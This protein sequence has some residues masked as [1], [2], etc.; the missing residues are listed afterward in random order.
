[1]E[2]PCYWQPEEEGPKL[3]ADYFPSLVQL[4]GGTYSTCCPICEYVQRIAQR[5][6]DISD[7]P[8]YPYEV[9]IINNSKPEAWSLPEG[10]VGIHR[11]LLAELCS[12]SEL[13]AVIARQLVRSWTHAEASMLDARGLGPGD[14][15]KFLELTHPHL[16][17]EVNQD[18]RDALATL[19]FRGSNCGMEIYEDQ[20][21]ATYLVRAGYDPYAAVRS[22]KRFCKCSDHDRRYMMGCYSKD[23]K[24]LTER[25]AYLEQFIGRQLAFHGRQEYECFCTNISRM[26]L[27]QEYYLEADEGYAMAYYGSNSL[28]AETAE[29]LI[30]RYPQEAIFW[31]LLG[32]ARSQQKL[33]GDALIAFHRAIELNPN[34]FDFYAQRSLVYEACG[35]S[36]QAI[37]DQIDADLL[38]QGKVTKKFKQGWQAH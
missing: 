14:Y 20:L 33:Y 18:A 16:L 37:N 9:V 29:A 27:L 23:E 1:M 6:I 12:E 36:A 7:Y 8:D 17:A 19:Y 28:A 5:V 35:Q 11:A 32:L 21:V 34:F 3:T 10:K 30:C 25:M 15:E 38:F 13:A 2:V 26:L 22:L 4:L 31:G 24:E